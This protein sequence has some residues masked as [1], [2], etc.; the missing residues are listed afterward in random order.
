MPTVAGRPITYARTKVMAPFSFFGINNQLAADFLTYFETIDTKFERKVDVQAFLERFCP[1]LVIPFLVLWRKFF[2]GLSTFFIRGTKMATVQGVGPVP[3]EMEEYNRPDYQTFTFFL[4]MLM[5]VKDK[6]GTR[7]LYWLWFD[8]DDA[9]I[10]D[11]DNLLDMLSELYPEDRETKKYRKMAL[12][13]RKAT[14]IVDNNN[15]NFKNFVMLDMQIG[16]PFLNQLTRIQKEITVFMLDQRSWRSMAEVMLRIRTQETIKWAKRR[17]EE[18]V[19]HGDSKVSYRSTGERKKS[20]VAMNKF[21]SMWEHFMVESVDIATAMENMLPERKGWIHSLK[22]YM[23]GKMDGD[24]DDANDFVEERQTAFAEAEAAEA[25]MDSGIGDVPSEDGSSFQDTADK[26]SKIAAD[27]MMSLTKKFRRELKWPLQRVYSVADQLTREALAAVRVAVDDVIPVDEIDLDS[28]LG[29]DEEWDEGGRPS[30]VDDDEYKRDLADGTRG[31][32]EDD[33][34]TEKPQNV[35]DDDSYGSDVGSGEDN[36]GGDD[37]DD[38][39]DEEKD[40]ETMADDS[41]TMV[42]A[43]TGGGNDD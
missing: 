6:E 36:V 7:W 17:L 5:C 34:M 38:E 22:L 41:Q 1:R 37:E 30:T 28:I 29:P 24:D 23:S 26:S 27:D 15:Y 42:S 31:E 3:E 13:L 8:L 16:S 39:D 12:K 25:G 11:S 2:V 10:V 4:L 43:L 33:Y 35:G 32:D 18:R 19:W 9:V 21:I 40:S 14:R 20:R